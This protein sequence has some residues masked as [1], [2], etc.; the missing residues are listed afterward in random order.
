MA[1]FKCCD[2]LFSNRKVMAAWTR[3]PRTMGLWIIAGTW[4][5]SQELDGFVPDYMV[6]L[7][8]AQ[9]DEIAAV[10]EDEGLWKRDAELDGWRFHDFLDYNP[11]SAEL[12]EKR[13]KEATRK[14]NARG[15][16]GVN[17]SGSRPDGLRADVNGPVPV[18]DPVTTESVCAGV[19]VNGKP[20]KE[21]AWELTGAILEQF[22]TQTD[23]KLRVVTSSGDPSE[24]AKRVYLRVVKYPDITL[25]KHRDIIART[26]SS[27]WWG[28]GAPT[29]GVVYGPKVFEENITRPAA[30]LSKPTDL[31]AER[32]RKRLAA[33][34]RLMDGGDAA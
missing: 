31:K 16:S 22:N 26:L 24:A 13:D 12:R 7:W 9:G 5:A 20:V 32:D 11:S 23:S 21:D 19:R 6:K 10:L 29:I 30:P 25:E 14:A 15:K 34:A 2:T 17:V 33:M 1:W 27:K 28:N 3:D 4:S 18:P 8:S